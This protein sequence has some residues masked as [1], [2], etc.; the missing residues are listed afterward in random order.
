M[1]MENMKYMHILGIVYNHIFMNIY[2]VM[3]YRLSAHIKSDGVL[4]F[5]IPIRCIESKFIGG[6]PEFESLLSGF[7]FCYLLPVKL[8]PRLAF[9]VLGI[10]NGSSSTTTNTN[11][12]SNIN[13]SYKK[14]K[15]KSGDQINADVHSKSNWVTIARDNMRKFISPATLRRFADS[16]NDSA[17]PHEFSLKIPSQIV[18]YELMT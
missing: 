9:F 3:A 2:K 14:N 1:L 5:V 18:P 17:G 7:G 13:S 10:N 8:T 16:C 12:N 11:T 4:L 15:G 6:L